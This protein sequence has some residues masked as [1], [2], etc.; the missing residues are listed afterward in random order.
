KHIP[1]PKFEAQA[2]TPVP[3]LI[4]Q[5][6]KV[7]LDTHEQ[8]VSWVNLSE[9]DAHTFAPS[10]NMSYKSSD[11]FGDE[12]LRFANTFLPS[13][14]PLQIWG[15]PTS[16]DNDVKP[17]SSSWVRRHTC[18]R[19]GHV[20]QIPSISDKNAIYLLSCH[21]ESEW[22]YDADLSVQKDQSQK[23]FIAQADGGVERPTGYSR[24]FIM[25]KPGS[26]SQHS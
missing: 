14:Q 3:G 10:T 11:L 17:P 24:A 9:N 12:T 25:C 26:E 16:A 20:I 22:R 7:S 5:T 15:T 8:Q 21:D 23:L 13:M 18:I 2:S 6:K 19:P 1:M 4:Q